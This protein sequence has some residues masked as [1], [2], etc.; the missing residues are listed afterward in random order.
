MPRKL[1]ITLILILFLFP[2]IS[3]YYLQRGL[4]WRK[5]AQEIMKGSQPFPTGQ[6]QDISDKKFSSGQLEGNVTLVTY[7]S[8]ENPQ[9]QSD[10]LNAFYLQF[11][12]SK[13]AYFI[14]LDTCSTTSFTSDPT[15]INWH[16]F[17]CSDSVDLCNRLYAE[18]PA[19]KNHA[20]VDR[21][22]KI[23]SYYASGTEEEKRIL[24]EHM[25][26]LLP[27]ERSD[28]VELKR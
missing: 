15:K 3:W 4:D 11:K 27:R 20:L 8:C 28:K 1:L 21:H 18:W 19:G 5:E 10:L 14:I 25:A 17:S 16:I 6:W 12:E 23:R 9:Q 7:I 24:L 13:K 22:Q 2:F 26:L